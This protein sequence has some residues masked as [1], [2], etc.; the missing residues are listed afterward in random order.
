MTRR[1]RAQTAGTVELALL[2]ALA[3]APPAHVE[4]TAEAEQY[5]ARENDAVRRWQVVRAN[6]ALPDT[7]RA[8]AGKLIAGENFSNKHG[9]LAAPHSQVEFA[10]AGRYYVRAGAYSAGTG[11]NSIHVGLNGEWPESGRRVRWCEGKNTWRWE[12]GQR[13]AAN[14]CGEPG[15][16]W[17][18]AASAGW[19]RAPFS[20]REDGFEFDRFTLTANPAFAAPAR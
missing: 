7:R 3:A 14:H 15:K 19:H 16:I 5:A 17:L 9:E 11:D 6:H 13:T 12:S 4:I 8:Q 10:A 1:T 2:A 20:M 18:D